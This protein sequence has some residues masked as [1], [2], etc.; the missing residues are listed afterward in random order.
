VIGSRRVKLVAATVVILAGG[1]TV[2][3]M[4]LGGG[5]EPLPRRNPVRVSAVGACPATIAGLDG[6]ANPEADGLDQQMV[7]PDPIGGLVCRFGP[8]TPS[9]GGGDLSR[10][11]P[12]ATA[13]ATRLATHVNRI[14]SWGVGTHGCGPGSRRS[15]DVLV[16]AYDAGADID[17][18]LDRGACTTIDNGYLARERLTPQVIAQFD[19]VVDDLD[20]F[21]RRRSIQ[22]VPRR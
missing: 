11:V 22:P 6:V 7:R 20:A 15:I 10:V 2:A 1:A 17:V 9:N 4:A 14:E 8:I 13:E 5:P 19:A 18:W 16:F 3:R 21:T 12:L